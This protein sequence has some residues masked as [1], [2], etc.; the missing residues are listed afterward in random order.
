[1]KKFLIYVLKIILPI[2]IFLLVLEI[3]LRKIPNDY[4]LKKEYLDKNASEI[5]TLILGSSH[6]FYGINPNYFSKKTFNAAYVS[7]SLDLDY[8]ILKTYESKFKNL[9]TVIIPISYFSLFETLETDIEKWRM[10]NYVLYYDF[11][12]KT[13]L[14]NQFEILN[15]DIKSNL[16]KTIKHYVLHKSFIT[17][18]NLG[19]GTNFN[20]KDKKEFKGE[21]TAKKHT[22]KNFDLLDDNLKTLQKIISLC[23]KKNISIIFITTPT[24][25]S[26]YKNLNQ[27]QLEKTHKVI[28]NLAITNSNCT[29]IN[30][31]HSNNYNKNDFYDADHLNEKGAKKLSL[32]LDKFKTD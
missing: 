1:M 28:N 20:S 27:I 30:L 13:D 29:Y 19:W 16:K 7:Q 2:I 18:S 12:I 9:K 8:E 5:N 32:F 14:N 6:T 22:A 23:H 15:S 11:P 10:K 3:S 21:F 31:M 17:S 26:Y 4:Q 24:H 25:S